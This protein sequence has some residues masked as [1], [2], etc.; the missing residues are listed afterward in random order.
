MGVKG[1]DWLWVGL[2]V[3]LDLIKWAQIADNRREI[4]GY[5]EVGY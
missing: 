2:G 4:P 5:T 3:V 1:W